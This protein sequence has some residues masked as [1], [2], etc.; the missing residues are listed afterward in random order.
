MM[1]YF[2]L[3]DALLAEGFNEKESASLLQT[4]RYRPTHRCLM[5]L[6]VEF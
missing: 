4:R 3:D 2:T 5:K 6:K 1:D